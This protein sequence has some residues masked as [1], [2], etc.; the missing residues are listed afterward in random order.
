M[1]PIP[2]IQSMHRWEA[3][4][5]AP[6]GS[7]A[8]Q[9]LYGKDS[10]AL[11]V[12]RY[13]RVL[14]GF[15]A[16][17]GE[18]P[19]ALISAPGRTE[20]CGNHTDH[21]HGRVL[22]AAVSLDLIA[23]VHPNEGSTMRVCS[24]GFGEATVSLEN[25]A[26][27]AAECGTSAALVRGVAAALR[28]AGFR[29][30]GFDAFILSDVPQGSGLSS[31]AAFEILLGTIHNILFNAG[32]IPPIELAKAGQTAEN[33]YFGKPCGLMD[34]AA[35]ALGGA[36]CIDFANPDCPDAR[37]VPC[38]FDTHGV[39]LLLTQAAAMQDLRR[40]MPTS[41]RKCVP[42]QNAS[43]ARYCARYPPQRSVQNFLCC[44][45]AYPTAP[46]CAQCTFLRKTNVCC[47]WRKHC[48]RG[49]WR[50]TAKACWLPVHPLWRCCKMSIRFP[51]L[52]SGAYPLRLHSQKIALA[53][54]A[55][56]G[57]CM[58]AA[59]QAQS[60]LLCRMHRR[61]LSALSLEAYS[62]LNIVRRLWCAQWVAGRCL[63]CAFF[64]VD[65]FFIIFLLQE[66]YFEL[67]DSLPAFLI[68]N[69]FFAFQ[70]CT[71]RSITNF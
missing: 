56:H 26:P 6:E 28:R 37:K 15:A 71:F 65:T 13:R 66:A 54:A 64:I 9:F 5:S 25:L 12:E 63:Q 38:D 2:A 24:E 62:E 40:N 4:F 43:A 21:Q 3:Y 19:V 33:A 31:S 60:R 8:F 17:F 7:S 20:L 58:A 48:K 10:E 61:I 46:F 22:A 41:L 18:F 51:P 29:A 68:S 35:S 49:T 32:T 30:G 57:V 27:C 53:H 44:A 70:S 39:S 69:L 34:Q 67:A 1:D 55:A 42:L 50:L 47:K 36:H 52:Q 14:C 45:G 11:Q 59:L 16:R 23:A